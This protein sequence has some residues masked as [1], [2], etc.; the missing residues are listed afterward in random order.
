MAWTLAEC[1]FK[2]KLKIRPGRH[3][4]YHLL[5]GLER[6]I[7]TVGPECDRPERHNHFNRQD[8]S[9]WSLQLQGVGLP[10]KYPQRTYKT[11]LFLRTFSVLFFHAGCSL[12]AARSLRSIARRMVLESFLL[13]SRRQIAAPTWGLFLQRSTGWDFLFSSRHKPWPLQPSPP[14]QAD[15]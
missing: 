7:G 1:L 5:G 15:L 14:S 9:F 2:D 6:G 4:Q 11:S 13:S 12:S 10:K 3:L 8:T